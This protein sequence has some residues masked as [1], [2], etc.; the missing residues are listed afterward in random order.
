MLTYIHI[1]LELDTIANF[2]RC[3]FEE[4]DYQVFSLDFKFVSRRSQF[5]YFYFKLN[6]YV[7]IIKNNTS[8]EQYIYIYIV[9]I[10]S[11]SMARTDTSKYQEMEIN[12]LF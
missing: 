12:R 6:K 9:Y 3:I 10:Y 5:T 2:V 7:Y 8:I 4:F 1:N 11:V